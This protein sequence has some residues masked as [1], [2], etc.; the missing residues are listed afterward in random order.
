MTRYLIGGSVLFDG[1]HCEMSRTD[2]GEEVVQMGAAA[3]RCLQVLLEARGEIVTKK[4][5]LYKGWE[6]YRNVVT[7]NSINQAVAQVRKGLASL[8]MDPKCI[9]TVPRIGYKIADDFSVERLDGRSQPAPP[10]K[11]FVERPF[12]EDPPASELP[13]RV[14]PIAALPQDAPSRRPA[15]IWLCF[16]V[17]LLNVAA[18]IGSWNFLDPDSLK[19]AIRI[20]YTPV[21]QTDS[22]SYFAAK[23]VAGGSAHV[24]SS[25]AMLQ[26][27]PSIK[28]SPERH[29]YVYINGALRGNVY[30]YFLCRNELAKKDSQ[31]VSYLILLSDG[32][33]R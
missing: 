24:E 9:I 18:A 6:Q 10:P 15:K 30:S 23:D 16:A 31:C 7:G 22:V 11:P 4:D 29:S 27:R 21:R 8:H 25:I 5:L 33:P 19:N 3:S 32:E 26:Q 28:G 17:M 2:N 1:D 13:E 14:D 12:V 20:E